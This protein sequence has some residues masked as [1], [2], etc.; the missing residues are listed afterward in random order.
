MTRLAFWLAL[1]AVLVLALL[2]Q[3]AELPST[4][5]DKSNHLLAFS[6]LSG[7]GC[8]GYPGRTIRVLPALIAFGALV[9]ALQS[10]T[11]DRHAEAADLVADALG[12]LLGWA[13]IAGWRWACAR[14][15]R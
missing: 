13:F 7:L 2:P 11:P 5:W 9:E 3:A 8:L 1:L 4:G 10:L 12:V 15:L 14:A 6:V